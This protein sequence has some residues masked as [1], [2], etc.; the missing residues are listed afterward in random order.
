MLL[1]GIHTCPS[2]VRGKYSH[3]L[4]NSI[5]M[6]Y[7]YHYYSPFEDEEAGAQRVYVACQVIYLVSDG[8]ASEYI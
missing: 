2:S 1:E 3:S 6:A 8:A 7:Y 5:K 4:R